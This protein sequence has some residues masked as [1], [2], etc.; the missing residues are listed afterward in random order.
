MKLKDIISK[1]E[2]YFP[3]TYQEDYD[4]AGLLCGDRNMEVHGVNICL[5]VTE[6][7]LEESIQNK[8]NVIVAHHPV[9]FKG[10]KK[11]NGDNYVERILIKAIK[12]DVAIY[13]VHTNLDNQ[14]HGINHYLGNLLGMKNIRILKPV[15][16]KLYK[17]SVFCPDIKLSDGQYVPG[18]VR[19]AMFSAGAGRIGNY[20]SCSF[21][22][23]G[24]GTYKGLEGTTPFLGSQGKTNVQ[25]EIKIE[26]IVPEHAKA[27]VIRN[28]LKA[29]PYE[30]V[31]YDVFPLKNVYEK[32]GSGI[33]GELP[34]SMDEKDF[35]QMLKDKLQA[36]VIRHSELRN[37]AVEKVAICGGSG[38]FLLKEAIR[39]KADSFVSAD[40]KY[41]EFF[42]ADKKILISDVGH[43]ES[44]QFTI[45]VLHELLIKN[46]T[47]FAISKTKV[48]TNPIN[49]F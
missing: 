27:A 9:L 18:K 3:L 13:A 33:M 30:E 35:L 12:N 32:A 15:S 43:Y 25:K 7:V 46:F 44:E 17:I 45:D 16:D 37:Q 10:I 22:Y 1:I 19:N 4:N 5:D 36:S 21:N 14:W 40:F 38:S 39:Q 2:D 20:D 29:H 28:M 24:Y 34:A 48:K 47:T 8:Q 11:L 26:S 49:Y 23:D 42:D 31:A 6:E 41:H